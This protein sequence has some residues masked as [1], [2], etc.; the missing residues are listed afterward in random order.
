MAM[1]AF[2]RRLLFWAVLVASIVACWVVTT[3]MFP[4]LPPAKQELASAKMTVPE[5]QAEESDLGEVFQEASGILSMYF[6]ST[7]PHA[8]VLL[9]RL[10][11]FPWIAA[12]YIGLIFFVL[13]L[14]VREMAAAPPI[15]RD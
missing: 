9:K 8:T 2:Y 5:E 10:I 11:L 13:M 6:S 12:F 3:L 14:F 15:K 1:N 4:T 7:F